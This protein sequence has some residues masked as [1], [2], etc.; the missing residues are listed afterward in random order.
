MNHS[1]L[2]NVTSTAPI[3]LFSDGFQITGIYSSG[4]DS[5]LECNNISISVQPEC[6]NT[7]SNLQ[8]VSGLNQHITV[9]SCMDYPD[10]TWQLY[11]KAVCVPFFFVVGL[12]GNIL[13]FLVMS[14]P[15]YKSKSYSYY[16]R[17]LAIFDSLTLFT[18]LVV[19]YNDLLFDLK[20]LPRGFL[21]GH[22]A[23]TCKICEFMRHVIYVMSSWLI[24]CFTVDRLIAV[25]YPL[26]RGRLCTERVAM[27][28]IATVLA[29]VM[30]CQSYHLDYVTYNYRKENPHMPCHASLKRRKD[31]IGINSL[32]FSF[33][34][35]FAI[36][37]T[38]MA[39]CNGMIIF[40]IDHMQSVRLTEERRRSK[41]ANLAVYTLYAVCAMFVLTLLP[42]AV[43]ALMHY[44]AVTAGRTWMFYCPL[45]LIDVP[46][47]MIR[48]MNYSLNFV[49]YGLTGRQFRRELYKI[50]Y[51]LSRPYSKDGNKKQKVILLHG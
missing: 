17:A 9:D 18:T 46:F 37:F 45:R 5:T 49:L 31:Y 39:I 6:L 28:T 15:V 2:T 50:M 29:V 26:Q 13:S 43:F 8:N 36:P 14:Q 1:V 25:C 42:N 10:M 3:V 21:Y 33:F 44:T 51:R 16:L 24:M 47:Q 41:K 23:F 7:S 38:V 27:T 32:W 40:H 19:Q 35:R 20:L 30:L 48:L 11:L 4:N 34:L 22:T 12:F